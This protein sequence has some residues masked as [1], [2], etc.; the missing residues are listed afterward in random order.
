MSHLET[1]CAQTREDVSQHSDKNP[2]FSENLLEQVLAQENMISAWKH[3]RSNKGK[4][5]IDGITIEAFPQY[6][7]PHWPAIARALWSGNYQPTPVKRVIIDKPDGGKRMLGVPI[8]L[9]RVIE[10]AIAQV[11]SPLFE[12]TFSEF[13]YGY[14]PKRSAHDAIKQVQQYVREGR[15]IAVDVDLSKF[16]DRI[17]HDFLMTQLGK[18]IRDKTLL[19]LIAKYLRAGI[20]DKGTFIESREGVPQ[21]SPLSPLLSNLVL[22]LLDKEL[23]K[24]G[25]KF[26]RYA[27]DFIIVVKSHRA[28]ERVLQSVTQYVEKHLKLKVNDQKSQVGPINQSKFL[29]FGFAGK[30]I[31]IHPRSMHKFKREVRKFSGRSWGVSMQTKIKKLS[32][33]LR[34]WMNYFGVAMPYQM[35]VDL[36]QWIRR[37]IRMC[38]WKQWR[39]PRTK[40]QN[41]IKLGVSTV[42]A[43]S[44][45]ISSKG[46]WHSA[47]TEGIQI[48]LNNKWL[49]AQGLVSLKDIWIS[50][51]YG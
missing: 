48:A 21:G 27:D 36:D 32:Q 40:I 47:R 13:S 22:D 4:P 33:Y 12:P 14:R 18:R 38:F 1:S 20:D 8:I 28:G 30:K 16:F 42:L 46:Y 41:L 11:L 19:K 2:V 43:I 35:S 25:H 34:G 45:G 39:K 9:D 26:A 10:Q 5:G 37:R 50:L 3:V 6:L 24:R 49:I 15:S 44:C 17:N 29:G 23:E 31:I 7:K 51:R